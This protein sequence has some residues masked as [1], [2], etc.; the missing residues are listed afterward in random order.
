MHSMS[1]SEH[2][3]PEGHPIYIL[4]E[5]HRLLTEF[6]NQ[7]VNL[8]GQM[9]SQRDYSAAAAQLEDAKQIVAQFRAS[10]PHY[11]REENVIFPYCDKHGFSGPPQVMWTEHNQIRDIEKGM[12][13]LMDEGQKLPYKEFIEKLT[14]FASL[15]QQTLINHF[16]KENNILFPHAL[17]L[18]TSAEWEA[19]RREFDKIGYCPFTPGVPKAAAPEPGARLEVSG[20]TIQLSTGSMTAEQLEAIFSTLPVEITFIDP[21]DTLRYFSQPTDTIF[22]R[23]T[24][25]LG[26]KV[27]NCHPAKSLHVVNQI[28]ADFKSGKRDVAEF[29]IQF[30]GKFVYIRYFAVRDRSGKYLGCMEVTQDIQPLKQVEGEKRLL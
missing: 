3:A 13:G 30:Q 29:W 22:T 17:E 1:Q 2:I 16:F 12:F 18:F 15:Q 20:G 4:M 10:M 8:A 11:L 27:Q 28:I 25:A 6:A 21:D 26:L 23:T 7:L 9:K 14:R 24:A 5:E 19:A